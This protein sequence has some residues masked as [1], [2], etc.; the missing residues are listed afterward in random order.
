[1]FCFVVVVAVCFFIFVL[2]QISTDDG[3]P[4]KICGQCSRQV[5]SVLEYRNK[6]ESSAERLRNIFH[7][8]MGHNV[9][10]EFD[11][12]IKQEIH[13]MLEYTDPLQRPQ[14][15]DDNHGVGAALMDGAL[16]AEERQAA[17]SAVAESSKE[18]DF[19]DL[20]DVDSVGMGGDD[21][22]FGIDDDGVAMGAGG[23]DDQKE[24]FEDGQS[25]AD[26]RAESAVLN[27]AV[28]LDNGRLQCH[29]CDKSLADRKTLQ[30]HIR[31]HTGKGLKRCPK[32]NKG[33]DKPNLLRKHMETHEID[34]GSCDTCKWKFTWKGEKRVHGLV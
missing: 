7:R 22:Y 19:S 26:R 29:L 31:R 33:F 5:R 24:D 34:H 21:D 32:C 2:L 17:S 25:M 27:A 11:C 18:F 20:S 9:K 6:I 13:F 16:T 1:M 28:R 3:L 30:H 12:D 4:G 14:H 23:D 8:R 10:R 15:D